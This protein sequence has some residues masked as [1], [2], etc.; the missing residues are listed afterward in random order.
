[1]AL[2][3]LRSKST[4]KLYNAEGISFV[5]LCA[6]NGDL[7]GVVMVNDDLNIVELL[8]PGEASF[9]NYI[10]TYKRTSG[11]L[12]QTSLKWLER[13]RDE[14]RLNELDTSDE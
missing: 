5:E 1:M 13:K 2:I 11:K 6:G 9:S 3:K 14:A 12:I 10:K 4:G 7:V 8:R